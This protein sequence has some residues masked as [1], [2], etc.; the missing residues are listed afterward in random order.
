MFVKTIGPHSAKIMLVGEAPGEEE[1]R[2]GKPFMGP[3]GRTLNQLLDQAEITRAE[4]LITNIARERPPGNKIAFY[5]EDKKMT[6][7]KPILK[8][9]LGLLKGEI[10]MYKPNVVVALGA[11]A[12][13]GLCGLKGISAHRG[14]ITESTLVPGQKVLP[15]YHPQK[16]NYEWKLGFTAVMDLRKAR[17]NS[18]TPGM[19]KE[20]RRLNAF[21]SRTE[22]LDYLQ[23][24][25]YE[26]DKPISLDIETVMPGPHVDILG[27]ADSPDHAVSFTFLSN[28]RPRLQPEKEREVWEW[29]A[30]V[31]DK[32][33]IVMH[34]GLY[35]MAVLWYK[36]GILCKNYRHDT[37][38]ACHVCWPETPRSLAYMSSICL[39]VP[40]WKHTSTT[41]P[42]LY[43]CADAANT[44]GVWEVME[45]EIDKLGVRHTYEEEMRQVWPA[46]KLQLAGVP[47]D[48]GR[49]N[50]IKANIRTR[51][52]QLK[53]ELTQQ[54]GK[55]VNLNSPK[56]LQALLYIDMGLPQQ[57][58]R[59]KSKY[60]QRKLTADAE[61]LTRLSRITSNPL[62]SKILEVKKLEKLQNTFIDISVSPEGSVHT[63]YNITGATM[64]RQKKGLIIDD[65]DSYKSFGRWSS[66]QS[67]I[68]PYGSGNLQNIPYTARTIYTAGE[69]KVYVQA[70]YV[71]A[72]AV[73]VAFSIGDEPMKQ[74][75]RESFGLSKAERTARNLDIHKITAHTNFGVP[76]DRVTSAQREVGKVIRH[77]TNYSAGPGVLSAKLGCSMKEAKKLLQQFHDIC[78]QLRLWHMRIQDELRKTRMLT[79]LLGR[80]HRFLERW[81]DG[82]FRS[83]YSYIPQSSVGD[84][85]NASLVRIYEKHGHWIDIRLQLHDAIYC[86]VDEDRVHETVV[87]LRESMLRP[88]K[89]DGQEFTI[90]VDFA[91]GPSWGELEDYNG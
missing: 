91:I 72:E 74:L 83:A 43:N 46:T 71:Q 89:V 61:A 40:A 5:F 13:W 32:R 79:N 68:L 58:K 85:L 59:R 76:V 57:Y 41:M 26:H 31:C 9:W 52:S 35:D 49:R 62:L 69:G 53:G 8:E 44:L 6:K 87:A 84:L 3:A 15:T 30:R 56:Q 60:D 45:N 77:A 1:D 73:V 14:F 16:V 36:L 25:Y 75:F 63:S 22:Y 18:D 66:S 54:F 47:V 86:I 34:N 82:L 27:I 55:E 88:L 70:D 12:L 39:N 67:I 78:P 38:I 51:L 20:T 21:P 90:D 11:T 81:G 24:L 48:V 23:Y 19:P 4:C 7:P 65:E 29:L 37:M 17:L 50:S 64:L 42:A 10:Q 33:D 2:S 28:R 80:K